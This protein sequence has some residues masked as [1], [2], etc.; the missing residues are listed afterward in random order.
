MEVNKDID[1]IS[2]LFESPSPDPEL[3]RLEILVGKWKIVGATQAGPTG[4]AMK[5]TSLETY[6]WL[7]GGFFLVHRWETFFGESCLDPAKGIQFFGYDARSRKYRTH[8]FDNLGPYDE[9]GSTYEGEVI[10]G[11]L[12]FTGPARFTL[13]ANEDG[14]ITSDW[15]LRDMDT[16]WIPWMHTKMTRIP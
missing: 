6:E 16:T 15:E 13:V 11:I 9:E 3:K 10:N 14:T 8:F 7:D 12:T 2:S 1:A 5:V 4:P